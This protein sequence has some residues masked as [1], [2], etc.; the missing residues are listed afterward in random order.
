MPRA[1]AKR[2]RSRESPGRLTVGDVIVRLLPLGSRGGSRQRARA[3]ESPRWW[4][5]C[6]LWP[7]DLFAVA[8]TL[9]GRSDCYS[10]YGQSGRAGA[11][12]A[13]TA[14]FFNDGY[15]KE[16]VDLGRRWAGTLQPPPAL[17][18]LWT[19]LLLH[20][21]QAVEPT[22]HADGRPVMGEW[23]K[24]A[25]RLMAIADEA[26]YGIGF[27]I[28]PE[29]KRARFSH[30]VVHEAQASARRVEERALKH[31]PASVCWHVP[32]EECCVLPKCRTPQVGVTLAALSHNLALLPP[33]SEV[34]PRWIVNPHEWGAP[35]G[36]AREGRSADD[37]G[38]PFNLLLIPFPYVIDGRCFEPAA[39]R[40]ARGG[41][42]F[43]LQ[44][45][46]IQG[47]RFTEEFSGFVR[48]LVAAAERQVGAVHGVVLPELAIDDPTYK[49]LEKSLCRLGSV[50]VLVAGVQAR[51]R[52]GSRPL[53]EVRSTFFTQGKALL[54]LSQFK[55]HR[56][57]LDGAQICRYQLGHALNPNTFWWEDIDV[58]RRACAFYVF[59][60]G[61]AL[62]FLVCEDLARLEPVQPVIRAVGPNLVIA[63]LMDGP[64]LE[65]RW[66][67]RYATVLT[68]DPGSAVLTLTSLGMVR[69][70]S[71][72]G[73]PHSR[74]IALWKQ[75]GGEARELKLPPGAH[76]LVASLALSW[77]ETHTLDGRSDQG[78]SVRLA[79]GGVTSVT[80]P[81]AAAWAEA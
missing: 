73:D 55:H 51:G 6:P 69:R 66:P 15:R 32:Q 59:R 40:T 34:W 78:S 57:K 50:E 9:V 39:S 65:R 77:E 58:S 81:H 30:L 76:G 11:R 70:S 71:M 63:L 75:P 29:E 19:E 27:V 79:L 17:R 20:S 42:F 33:A 7:P 53:N 10:Y 56:W 12:A 47:N 18:S 37:E 2:G 23:W 60:R 22:R 61:A 72:P 31:L 28:P 64:Q 54:R 74:E 1:A 45:G 62:A 35:S 52:K 4:S 48:G 46:W 49:A 14:S 8:G 16:A 67:G 25:M 5:E 38:R 21:D 41:R 68:D 36:K 24:V 26:S 43:R 44:Q 3:M 80:H 13:E